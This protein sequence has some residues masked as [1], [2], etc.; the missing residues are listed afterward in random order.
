MTVIG[1]TENFTGLS[2][3]AH[4]ESDGRISGAGVRVYDVHFDN[5]DLAASRPFIA[6]SIAAVDPA[7][8]VWVPQLGDRHPYTVERW[9]YVVSQGVAVTNKSPFVYRVTVQYR[10]VVNP[11]EEPPIIEWLSASTSEV[12]TVDIDGKAIANSSDE[13]V[14]P[15]HVENFDDLILRATY[16][17]SDFDPVVAANYKGAVNSDLFLNFTPGLAK[18]KVFTGRRILDITD[19]FYWAVVVEIQFR[20]DGWKRKF[21]D[22]G[23]RT[24]AKEPDSDGNPV[25]TVIA[26]AVESGEAVKLD[27][28]GQLLAAGADDVLVEYETKKPLPFDIDSAFARIA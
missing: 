19:Q 15:P 18:V 8:G 20:K 11:L 13:P 22:E 10:E 3:D 28:Q 21:V 5:Q 1:V 27:G 12:I 14:D 4:V 24:K 17:V 7:T 23:F 16:N 9:I 2:A 25:Y 26:A 6:K